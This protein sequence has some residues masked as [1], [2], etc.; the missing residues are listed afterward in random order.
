MRFI[1]PLILIVAL[2]TSC[3]KQYKEQNK[4]ID[5]LLEGLRQSNKTLTEVDTAIVFELAD[6]V[7]RFAIT[8]SKCRYLRVRICYNNC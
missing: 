8:S 7:K 6:K 1:I 5:E 3:K 4:Q 2:F